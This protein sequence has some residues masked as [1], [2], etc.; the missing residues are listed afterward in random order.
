MLCEPLFQDVEDVCA[1]V[2]LGM[3]YLAGVHCVLTENHTN[4]EKNF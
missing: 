4:Q 3:F 1:H 2:H